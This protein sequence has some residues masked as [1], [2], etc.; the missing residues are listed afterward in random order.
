[1]GIFSHTIT[2]YPLSDIPATAQVAIDCL[3]HVKVECIVGAP[4]LLEGIGE[5]PHVLEAISRNVKTLFWA[6]GGI[7]STAGNAI[8]SK[9]KLYN[10][11]GSTEMGMWPT[12]QTSDQQSSDRWA[13]LRVHPAMNMEFRYRSNDLYEAVIIRNRYPQ[14][15]QPV[16]K[17]YPDINEYSSNDLFSPHPLDP[18]LWRH[19]GRVDDM[20]VFVTGEKFH[21]TGVEQHIARHPNVNEVLLVGT[22]RPQTALLIE[23]KP[24]IGFATV[25]GRAETIER[26]WPTLTEANQLSPSYAKITE[27]HILFTIP[28]KPMARFSKG[29]VQRPATVELYREELD[30]LF[31]NAAA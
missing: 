5:N 26:L 7:S 9:L 21:P 3:K 10:T 27:S 6:G 16:F 19:R 4:P 18:S 1:M 31:G 22:R 15:E 13:D 28:E 14:Y 8:A 2:I 23:M 20:Q 30:A 29:T 17:I 12:L 24:D 11:C 25:I